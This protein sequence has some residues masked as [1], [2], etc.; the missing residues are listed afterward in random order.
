MKRKA[1]KGH[2]ETTELFIGNAF[3]EVEGHFLGIP[4]GWEK[5]VAFGKVVSVRNPPEIWA[6][7]R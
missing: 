3:T 2:H 6:H 7:W 4:F 1:V 5:F